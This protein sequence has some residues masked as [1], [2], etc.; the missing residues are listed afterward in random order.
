MVVNDTTKTN[1][2]WK[3]ESQV[4]RAREVTSMRETDQ[5]VKGNMIYCIELHL[6]CIGL[7]WS[8]NELTAVRGSSM[9]SDVLWCSKSCYWGGNELW[10]RWV[11]NLEIEMW[12]DQEAEPNWLA[13][14]E[15]MA[16]WQHFFGRAFQRTI[17]WCIVSDLSVIFSWEETVGRWRVT[18][19]EIRVQVSD[20]IWRRL[21]R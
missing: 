11:L 9:R 18:V 13:W 1:V 4:K 17:S 14:G 19:I 10:K 3:S 21:C 5:G 12:I 2:R 15:R 6:D 8:S 20:W 16:G 7:H